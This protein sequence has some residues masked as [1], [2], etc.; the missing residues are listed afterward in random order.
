MY[1]NF[2]SVYSFHR[3]TTQ[4]CLC[5]N[6]EFIKLIHSL[7]CILLRENSKFLEKNLVRDVGGKEL[8]RN[9]NDDFTIDGCNN[10]L[11]KY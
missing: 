8:K 10:E 1:F 2:K 11:E 9:K 3:I 4:L 7:K 5:E 6:Q